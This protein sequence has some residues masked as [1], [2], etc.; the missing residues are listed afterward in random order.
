MT[1]LRELVLGTMY[2]GTRLDDEASFAILDRF[3][4]AGGRTIDTAN[5]YSFWESETGH[6]GQSEAV[7]GRWLRA[8]PGVADQVHLSTKVGAE[9][10]E[11]FGGG[12]IGEVEGLA[13][14]HVRREI[15]RSLERLGVDRLGT[16][17]AHLP[18]PRTDAAEVGRI[19][20]ELVHEGLTHH[21]GLS[22]FPTWQAERARGGAL[23]AGFAPLDALQL[24]TSY[25]APRPHRAVKGKDN[26]H[27]WV[28]TETLDWLEAHPGTQL[29]IYSPL[30]QGS[31]TN[32]ER[33][34]PVAYQH[35]GTELRLQTL[36]QVA[37]EVG[38]DAGQTVLTWM[39]ARGWRP[40]LGVSSVGQLDQ[41]LA[42]AAVDLDGE[43]LGRLD[44]AG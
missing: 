25:V 41:A 2:F 9:P 24:S 10:V 43:Q 33:P 23:A 34:L 39:L 35:P 3:V 19:L 11:P 20:G 28:T 27:G 7:I 32:P 36:A 14:E 21:V 16:Y 38:L 30:I 22:N 31:Y 8:R 17:W 4:E 1:D 42:S 26:P 15:S 18:D 40:V 13:R 29:W 44:H 6:G 5:C 37:A 12:E